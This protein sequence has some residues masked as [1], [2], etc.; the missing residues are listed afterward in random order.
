M[1]ISVWNTVQKLVAIVVS[2][3]KESFYIL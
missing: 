1:S 2:A 3:R